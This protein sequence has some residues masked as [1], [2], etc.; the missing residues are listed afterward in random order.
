MK[1]YVVGFIIENYISFF[2]L[3]TIII[4]SI[5]IF[6]KSKNKRENKDIKESESVVKN[7][8]LPQIDLISSK[9]GTITI[10]VSILLY[11]LF[12]NI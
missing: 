5:I 2:T 10:F 1:T 11:F 7:N 3:S 12:R 8:F 6:E 9:I 4:I